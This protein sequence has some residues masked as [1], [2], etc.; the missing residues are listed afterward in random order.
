MDQTESAFPDF[1]LT[2]EQRRFAVRG[3]YY[4]HPG[5]DGE[6]GEIWCY[7]DRFLLHAGRDSRAA[8]QFYRAEL[9]D[10]SHARRR[11]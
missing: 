1:G 5:M 7:T 4:E 9:R 2:P 3:C 6:S 10:G 8:C 11:S